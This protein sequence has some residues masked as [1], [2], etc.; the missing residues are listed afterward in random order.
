VGRDLA[1]YRYRIGAA[2][3]L[4]LGTFIATPLFSAEPVQP[5]SS[6]KTF[7]KKIGVLNPEDRT[8]GQY[9]KRIGKQIR[10]ALASTFRFEIVPQPKLSKELPLSTSDLIDLGEKFQLDGIING[11]VEVKGDDL[12]MELTLLEAKTGVSFAIEFLFV[13][14]FKSPDAIE[15][16]VRT[17]VG[18]LIGRIPYQAVVTAVQ[19][20]GKTVTIDA[21]RLH[22]LDNGMQLQVF[23]IVKVT[24]HPFTQEVIRVEKVNV[25][26]FTVVRADE[27]ISMAEPL[28]LEKGQVI[29]QGQ[30]V[31]F[32]PSAKILTEMGSRKDELL[33]GQEREWMALEEAALKE[34]EKESEKEKEKMPVPVRK[35]SRG[36]LA[37]EAGTAWSI[38][39]LN[40]DQLEFN[41]K[42]STFP[43]GSVSGELWVMPS[44][45]VDAG[46]QIG[47]AKLERVGSSSMSV[48]IRPYW[49]STHLKYRYILWPDTTHLELIGRA[50]Y[51]WYTYWVSETDSQ[52]MSNT[53]YRGPSMGLEGRLPL[54]STITVG[55][56]VD[57]QPALRVDE[58]PVTSG[59]DS[60]SWSIGLRAEGR[61]RL[62][63]GLWLSIRY[64]FRDF[65]ASYS[66]TGSRVGGVTG[67][68][69][70]D[71]LS[72]TM[73]GLVAEF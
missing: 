34:K 35:I 30:F 16:G 67:T 54:T 2:V 39:R 42:I 59:E 7:F 40:S 64:L 50:G 22:G 48:R 4:F 3:V 31:L 27:R 56:G 19:K 32:K 68:K 61:Y 60:T 13:K 24:R 26:T 63:S 9:G 71:D 47:F 44:L 41:R 69:T 23:R 52:F 20:N 37:V 15:N 53:R 43:L 45:G 12:K 65:V 62:H 29:S 72:S 33:A 8:H 18:K 57:Y 46:Y 1:N 21:G 17:I 5:Q 6:E 70:R 11:I 14:N 10:R 58:H 28:R 49:Y 25:G 66:G 73:L 55:M 38:F 36:E 51:A